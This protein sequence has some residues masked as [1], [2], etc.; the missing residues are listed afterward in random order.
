MN[1]VHGGSGHSVN[2]SN[3]QGRARQ[4]WDRGQRRNPRSRT[5]QLRCE[6]LERRYLLTASLEDLVRAEPVEL[7]P[8][9]AV[10]RAL[11]DQ[12]TD[13]GHADPSGVERGILAGELVVG[14]RGVAGQPLDLEPLAM[15]T[16]HLER[17]FPHEDSR[18]SAAPLI[19]GTDLSEAPLELFHF[20]FDPSSD[21]LELATDA[22]AFPGVQW[23]A[24]NYWYSG[25]IYDFVPNDEFYLAQYHHPLI[26]SPSAWDVTLGDPSVVIA[27]TDDGVQLDHPDLAANIWQNT[28]ELA[29]TPGVD[30]DGNG[31]VD[32]FQGWDF[33]R[34]DNDPSPIDPT[35]DHGTHVAGIAAG[36]TNNGLQIAGVAGGSTIM[37]LRI[38]GND[39]GFTSTIMANAFAY[40]IDNGA[41]I[42][43]TSYNINRFVGDPTF[44]AGLQYYY[45]NGGLH[46]NSAG[47]S[48]QLNPVRQAF[49]QT[50]LVA[51]TTS[52]DTKSSFS[53]Y[54]TGIDV[55]APGSSIVSTITGSTSGIK[56]GT[57]MA[58][59]NAAGAAA[60]IWSA[61]PTWTRDQVIAY[62][63]GTA[64]NIDASNPAYAGLLGSG[65]INIS[66]LTGALAAPQLIELTGLPADGA[67]VTVNEPITEFRLRFDQ[68]MDPAAMNDPANFVLAEAGPNGIAGD[69]DDIAVPISADSTYMIGSND[70]GFSISGAPLGIGDYVLTISPSLTNP[71]GTAL[72]GDGNGS[73]GD[74][75]QTFFSIAPPPLE[76]VAP[77]GSLIYRP[78]GGVPWITG[79]IS[80]SGEL[81]TRTIDLD[82]GGRLTVIVSPA[83]ALTPA[84]EVEGPGGSI[85]VASST[86]NGQHLVLQSLEITVPGTY[87]ILVG[88]AG[89]STGA[90][91]LDL[92]LNAD[93]ELESF[94]GPANDTLATAQ[95]IDGSRL[96]LGFGVADRLAVLGELPPSGAAEPGEDWYRF[97]TSP[98][99]AN[100]LAL[101]QLGPGEVSLELYDGNGQRLALGVTADQVDQV[102]RQY[103][104]SPASTHYARVIGWGAD[105]ALVITGDSDF[106]REVNDEGAAQVLSPLP[107]ATVLGAVFA[108]TATGVEPDDHADGAVLDG[109]NPAVVLSNGVSGGSIFAAT[110]GFGAPSG[111]RVF[112]PA[113]G[114]ASGFNQGSNELRADFVE[115]TLF[116]SIEAGS[117]D[118]SDISVLR[119]YSAGGTLLD[120]VVSGAIASGGSQTLSIS[121]PTADIAYA[122][123]FGLGGDISPLDDL[124]FGGSG[125][126]DYYTIDVASGEVLNISTWTPADGPGQ[127]N[128]LLDPG[129]EL[130]D[131]LGAAIPYANGA[132]DET[133][134]HTAAL[135]GEYVVRVFAEAHGGGYVLNIDGR[136]ATAPPFQATAVDPFDGR[137][138]TSVPAEITIAFSDPLL[139]SS[140]AADD[141]TVAGV[142]ATGVT[143]IDARTLRFQV[144]AAGPG[145]NTVQIAPGAILN[146]QGAPVESLTSQF[147]VEPAAPPLRVIDNGDSGYSTTG[148]TWFPGT[149]FGHADDFHFSPAGSGGDFAQWTFSGLTPGLYR[150]AATWVTAP[151]LSSAAPFTLFQGTSPSTT[152]NVN[153]Q[154]AP[155]DFVYQDS[156]WHFLGGVQRVTGN[157]LV[158]QL[159]TATD[160]GVVADAIH[161]EQIP[162]QVIDNGDDGYSREGANWFTSAAG[163]GFDGD[164]DLQAPGNG[165]Q[166]ARWT[167]TDLVPGRYRVSTT[168]LPVPGLA[169]NAPFTIFDGSTPLSTT[170]V[171]QETEPGT[172]REGGVRWE[173]L[174]E[175]ISLSGD[176]LVVELSNAADGIVTADAIHLEHLAGS[177]I[178]DGDSGYS[179]TGEWFA[180]AVGLGFG[181][182]GDLEVGVAGTGAE[183]ANWTFSDLTPGQYRV[184]ASW[185]PLSGL[186]TDAPFTILDGGTALATVDIDLTQQ[187]NDIASAGAFWHDLGDPYV[188]TGSTLVVQLSDAANSLLLADAIRIERVGEL[189][190]VAEAGPSQSSPAADG[191]D[192]EQ[193]PPTVGPPAE[194]DRAAALADR[195]FQRWDEWDAIAKL[196]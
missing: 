34:N 185:L 113:P 110:A 163:F 140:I 67:T 29:G 10:T 192:G 41:R 105:Y 180:L 142:P 131:P 123:A 177:I 90:Y 167:F 3:R 120:E 71:F 84:V 95:D 116:V 47:N 74:A 20:Q 52:S 25:D 117:D 91:E 160:G 46:F 49:E 77:P 149:G 11:R 169:T 85:A 118:S 58:A 99:G 190:S 98:G 5:R 1:P 122:I 109:V 195:V 150:V 87:R 48:D 108:T 164:I 51:S 79:D 93:V 125:N 15:L 22:L 23:V 14:Y 126:D 136:T 173:Q 155:A 135:S 26:G 138:L 66:N 42:A 30:D 157:T 183:T 181:F 184:S 31:Y 8:S 186:A 4:R 112:A 144:D 72:D 61:N 43:N 80:T 96:A 121:R 21:L 57:S 59:P 53:N 194:S 154:L 16:S 38:A 92:V 102:I 158:V 63:L 129:I 147:V 111:T 100:T 69:S 65:R 114:A 68:L 89:G 141:L 127:P 161:L 130:F 70:F 178:D 7:L 103:L 78:P 104:S 159:N 170:T 9:A 12:F 94:Q 83:A 56:S 187:P 148:G 166:R 73:G 6:S 119:A 196:F 151:D 97:T 179:T 189:P 88:G 168:W 39:G 152:V 191:S 19:R 175:E 193:S 50:I 81:D 137:I 107:N 37:P 101:Q 35:D 132:G 162:G 153:Q 139:L 17:S 64:D 146:L 174:G 44:T 106:D 165:E 28:V 62:L 18:V 115:P 45:D 171:N 133:L 32:D 176:T 82:A 145:T 76:P 86:A 156:G 55:S 13:G 134:N 24:P 172:T 75:Y 143:I 182:Q 27:I 128:N 40:A 124:R 54:G 60:L 36:I 2:R 33:V 188:I